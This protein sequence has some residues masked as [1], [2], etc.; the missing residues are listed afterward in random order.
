[1]P[2]T[3]FGFNSQVR[4]ADLNGDALVDL[5]ASGTDGVRVWLA[6]GPSRF[7]LP[8]LYDTPYAGGIEIGDLDGDGAPEIVAAGLELHVLS[9]PAMAPSSR[10]R[11]SRGSG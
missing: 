4:A 6:L 3:A 9:N 2:A 11:R 8:T 7:A 5:V 1:M 10:R